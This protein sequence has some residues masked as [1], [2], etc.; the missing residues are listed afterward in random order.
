MQG[1]IHPNPNLL[2]CVLL[3]SVT[4]N[5]FLFDVPISFCFTLP[6]TAL[7]AFPG[8]PLY[9]FPLPFQEP[10]VHVLSQGYALV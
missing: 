2:T 1:P 8:P 6:H 7:L 4:E 5:V 3:A 10:Q 9:V